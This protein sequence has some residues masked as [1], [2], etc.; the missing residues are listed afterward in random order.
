MHSLQA[1]DG[2]DLNDHGVFDDQVQPVTTVN[3]LILVDNG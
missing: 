2:L 1:L 3:A